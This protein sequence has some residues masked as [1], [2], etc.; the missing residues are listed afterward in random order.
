MTRLPSKSKQSED[1]DSFMFTI[2]DKDQNGYITKEELKS[3][4]RS[5]GLN[6]TDQELTKM[7]AEADKNKDHRISKS[8]FKEI[9]KR[10]GRIK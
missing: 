9:C 2:F 8:E 5:L 6:I 7:F 4:M 1:E 3:T 10:F